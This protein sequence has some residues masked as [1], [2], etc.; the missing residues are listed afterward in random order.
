MAEAP[1]QG[2][3]IEISGL[4]K[5]FGRTRVLADLALDISMGEVLTVLGPNGS[6][7]T[8]LI[9]ILATLTRPDKGSIRVLGLDLA[10]HGHQARRSIGVVTHEPMLY[11]DLTGYENLMLCGRLFRLDRLEDRIA[12]VA[13][14]MAITPRL[15]H[16]V[17][18]LSNGLRKRLSIARALLHNPL[19]L[20]MDEPESGLD[21]EALSILD[22]IIHYRSASGKT[23]LM[24]TH[25][26]ERGLSL[27]HRTAILAG[28]AIAHLEAVDSSTGAESL[29]QTYFR[30]TEAAR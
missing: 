15:H 20:L 5:G 24:T 30:Y 21:Q 3:A 14:R 17:G 8:T 29:R 11:A 1:R 28:G 27:G 6:G 2:A 19:V 12:E 23:V 13:E 18:T 7:K 9:K 26:L 22:E 25:N 10:S 16:R 4:S